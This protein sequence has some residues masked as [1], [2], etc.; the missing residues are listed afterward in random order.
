MLIINLYKL[1]KCDM[2]IFRIFDSVKRFSLFIIVIVLF[3]ACTSSDQV[4]RTYSQKESLVQ[5]VDSIFNSSAF[6]NAFWGV[7]IKELGSGALLFSRNSNKMFM[8]ASNQKIVTTSAALMKLKPDFR[9]TTELIANGQIVDSVLKGDLVIRADGDPTFYTRFYS[10]PLEIFEK[11]CDSLKLQGISKIEGNI[12][13]D[14]NFF[15]DENIGDGWPLDG[16][17]AW[18]SA[19]IGP[20]QLNENYIDLKIIPAKDTLSTPEILPN[21]KTDYI[22]IINNIKPV[23]GKT[24]R[25]NYTRPYKTNVITLSGELGLDADTLNLSPSIENPT[26]FYVSVL[27]EVL[28]KNHISVSGKAIDIDDIQ[29]SEIRENKILTHKSPPLKEIIK[30]LLKP[31]QNLYAETMVRILGKEFA[32]MGSFR[33]GRKIISEELKKMGVEPGTYAF[34]DGSGLTRYNYIAPE[35][36]NRILTSMYFSEYKNIWMDALPV[37]GID[38]TLRNRMKSGFAHGN[39]RAKTGTISNVRGLSG[40]FTS[41]SGKDY[42]FSFLVN[43]HLEESSAT[44]KV[45]DAVLELLC[46]S[47][48][49]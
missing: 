39:V 34:R 36:I 37:A 43:G 21:I 9:F 6:D 17:D 18:Y 4:I 15:D 16:L 2:N 29:T 30:H 28:N 13:G 41:R 31:S 14:D 38:G 40:Y 11:W 10:S 7:Q 33:N 44:D 47:D 20:L 46:A 24:R 48:A 35:Q 49:L 12:I 25:V 22:R 42:V 5:K 45:T 19:E 23:M 8:P 1:I 26:A 27:K 3:H 32:Q